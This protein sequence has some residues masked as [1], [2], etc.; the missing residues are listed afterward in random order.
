MYMDMYIEMLINIYIYIYICM[1]VCISVDKCIYKCIYTFIKV[2][3]LEVW[4]PATRAQ[5]TTKGG[6]ATPRTDGPAI[7]SFF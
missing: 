1:H 5:Y 2:W 3:A 6:S 7:C 4:G